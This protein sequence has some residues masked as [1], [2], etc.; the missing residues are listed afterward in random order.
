MAVSCPLV[1]EEVRYQIK[2][3]KRKEMVKNMPNKEKKSSAFDDFLDELIE[4]LFLV[5]LLTKALAKKVLKYSLSEDE[6]DE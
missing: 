2:K 4:G 3:T 5:S 6:K 1:G